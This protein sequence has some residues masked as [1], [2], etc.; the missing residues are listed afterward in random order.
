MEFSGLMGDNAPGKLVTI[1]MGSLSGSRV[2]SGIPAFFKLCL[3]NLRRFSSLSGTWHSQAGWAKTFVEV[4]FWLM[5]ASGGVPVLSMG[6]CQ[7]S[8]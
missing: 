3:K 5:S 1:G 8:T 7:R 6:A 4:P 2:R